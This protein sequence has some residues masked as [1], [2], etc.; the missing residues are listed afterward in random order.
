MCNCFPADTRCLSIRPSTLRFNWSSSDDCPL[1]CGQVV[2]LIRVRAASV[3]T[4]EM[5]AAVYRRAQTRSEQQGVATGGRGESFTQDRRVGCCPT[6]VLREVEQQAHQVAASVDQV[7]VV[8]VF[9]TG[10][11]DYLQ[12]GTAEHHIA[13]P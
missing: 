10:S 9:E 3:A 7:L 4:T 12:P 5:S 2:E 11:E 6:T 13:A 1:T 8:E